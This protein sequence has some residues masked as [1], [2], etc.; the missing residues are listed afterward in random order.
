MPPRNAPPSIGWDEVRL[1]LLVLTSSLAL[2][3]TW[4]Y[5]VHFNREQIEINIQL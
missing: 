3:L 4:I 1:V 5:C 2:S